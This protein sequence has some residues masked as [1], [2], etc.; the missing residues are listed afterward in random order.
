M[1][2]TVKML[3]LVKTCWYLSWK[4]L[5]TYNHI[6]WKADDLW[7]KYTLTWLQINE[8]GILKTERKV[9]CICMLANII[10]GVPYYGLIEMNFD[11][12]LFLQTGLICI[13]AQ[14][15]TVR[16]TRT[17]DFCIHTCRPL[18]TNWDLFKY[19]FQYTHHEQWKK[20]YQQFTLTSQKLSYEFIVLIIGHDP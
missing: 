14:L 7:L 17:Y 5:I 15:W 13:H 12:T 16:K 19:L 20:H 11:I 8:I 1:G 2:I 9:F 18:E 10:F 3:L 6:H 4:S